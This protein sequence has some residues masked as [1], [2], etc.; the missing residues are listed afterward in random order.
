MDL[1]Q[2]KEQTAMQ[3]IT[4]ARHVTMQEMI[5]QRQLQISTEK[6]NLALSEVS[7]VNECE[8]DVDTADSNPENVDV[9]VADYDSSAEEEE[10]VVGGG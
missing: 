7:E 1:P 10:E 2:D 4:M 3:E 9:E 8:E 5:Y 6:V